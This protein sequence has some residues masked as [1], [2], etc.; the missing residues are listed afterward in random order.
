MNYSLIVRGSKYL[1]AGHT[2][3]NIRRS[4]FPYVYD[5]MLVKN[6]LMLLYAVSFAFSEQV[7]TSQKPGDPL[8]MKYM[9]HLQVGKATLI[10]A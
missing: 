5:V 1:P 7:P 4:S 3:S 10:T 9:H 6:I 2:G 8:V